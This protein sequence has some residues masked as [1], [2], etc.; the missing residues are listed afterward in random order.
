MFMS[1]LATT[2]EVTVSKIIPAGAGWQAASV[3]ADGMGVG[4]DTALFAGITGVGDGLA[5]AAGHTGYY[6]V[7]KAL[8]DPKLD[9]KKQA[10]LGIW[11]G[12]A[13]ILSGGMW[14]PAV[15][16]LQAAEQ[17][18][19]Y[20]IAAA[21]GLACGSAFL[22]GLRAGRAVFPWIPDA[23][24]VNFTSDATLSMA[25]GGAS[26]CFVGTDV[27]YLGGEGNLL[28]PFVGIE[29]A[30]SILAGVVKAGASTGIGFIS[31]QSIQNVIYPA[32][33]AWLDPAPR[34]SEEPAAP[35]GES[36]PLSATSK[37]A[38]A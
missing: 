37:L 21:T 7:K 17:L 12:S 35:A 24:N 29:D 6:A 4:A 11:Y 13:A 19:C 34:V 31:A 30:D 1:R 9:V 36:A 3:V 20:A 2:L 26:G 18:P 23:D 14:Q 28:R 22:T 32:G 8:V 10:G 33:D 25:I 15:G 16:A 27:A 38:A 5:V